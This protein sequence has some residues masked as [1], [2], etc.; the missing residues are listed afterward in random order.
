MEAFQLEL[1]LKLLCSIRVCYFDS[2]SV[3]SMNLSISHSDAHSSL[4]LHLRVLPIFVALDLSYL[5]ALTV[6][7]ID[8]SHDWGLWAVSSSVNDL[9]RCGD[10]CAVCGTAAA[11]LLGDFEV[12]IGSQGAVCL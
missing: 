4:G 11:R 8:D 6:L 3:I 10:S 12:V 2:H 1:L 9:L 5:R 7:V